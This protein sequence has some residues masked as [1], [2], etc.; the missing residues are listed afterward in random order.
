MN[1]I[2]K[3][4]DYEQRYKLDIPI[5][6]LSRLNNRVDLEDIL[7]IEQYTFVIMYLALYIEKD[8]KIIIKNILDENIDLSVY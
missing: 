8:N 3:Y 4:I 5:Y 7:S 6:C 2:Y 1:E